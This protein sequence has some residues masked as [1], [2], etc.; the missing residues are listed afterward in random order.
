MTNEELAAE[1]AAIAG[2]LGDIAIRL[3]APEGTFVPTQ[4]PFLEAVTKER[5]AKEITIEDVR[6]VLTKV[7]SKRGAAVVKQLMHPHKKLSDIPY[8]AWVSLIEKAE[9]LL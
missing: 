6:A 7:S 3:S 2:R 4:T 8:P 9:E 1:I 5:P